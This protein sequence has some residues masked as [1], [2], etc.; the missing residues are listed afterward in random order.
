[1]V[2]RRRLRRDRR[3]GSPRSSPAGC[4]TALHDFLGIVRP[5]RDASRRVLVAR[6]EP[7]SE[8]HR[9]AGIPGRRRI[10]ERRAQRRWK[11]GASAR[12][13]RSPRSCSPPRSARCGGGG[14]GSQAAE[15]RASDCASGS[16]VCSALRRRRRGLRLPRLV[17]GARPRPDA[18]RAPRPRRL[19]ARLQGAGLGPTCCCSPTAIRTRIPRRSAGVGA[20]AASRCRLELDDDGRRSRLTVFFRLLLAL[21]PLR[22]AGALDD[23]R[24]PGG[25][26]ERLRRT[27][28]RPLC[29]AAAPIPRRLRPLLRPRGRV[30]HPRREPVPGLRRRA[31]ATR[32]TSRSTRP[33]GR[34]AGSRCSGSS[35]SIPALHR[36]RRAQRRALR[37]RA[38]SAGSP[39]S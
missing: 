15:R 26:R 29:R 33:S 7:V 19:R 9:H 6:R 18:A 25:D 2:D 23:C 22:L 5:L 38:S 16:A 21:P 14:G 35:S 11:I 28:P 12:C 32:S 30:R 34:T 37:R 27:H 36:L 10:P 39:R 17:R 8:L 20:A 1:M 3:A 31:R 24:V 4:R 13:S